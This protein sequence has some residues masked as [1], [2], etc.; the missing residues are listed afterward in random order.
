M[1][2][3]LP[4]PLVG[5]NLPE[6]TANFGIDLSNLY[7]RLDIPLEWVGQQQLRERLQTAIENYY[8]AYRR[9]PPQQALERALSAIVKKDRVD[10]GRLDEPLQE[11]VIKTLLENPPLGAEM[12]PSILG[13]GPGQKR[14]HEN[15]RIVME[16]YSLD[17]YGARL[18]MLYRNLLEQPVEKIDAL[19]PQK[20]LDG[21]LA[22]ES[23]SLLRN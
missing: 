6:I 18:E 11:T 15:K 9:N 5:R 13:S 7:Q 1:R 14:L 8:P 4:K 17:S 20:L 19:D 10:F 21:F 2:C 23:F 16:N 12:R 3:L 22:P